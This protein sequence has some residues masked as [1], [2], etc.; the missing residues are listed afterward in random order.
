MVTANLRFVQIRCI[1]DVK[2]LKTDVQT[3]YSEAE[4][5]RWEKVVG[6]EQ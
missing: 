2:R 1:M 4:G 5:L 6:R 3:E